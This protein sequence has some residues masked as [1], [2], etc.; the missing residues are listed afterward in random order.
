M[1]AG[2]ASIRVDFFS[3]V[4]PNS[5]LRQSYPFSYLTV[6]ADGSSNAQIL[7][8]IDDSWYG[9]PSGLTP[10]YQ[11]KRATSVISLT[12]SKAVDYTEVNDMA[13]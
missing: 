5:H 8:A 4:S 13:A 2:A 1:D 3:P 12:D 11:T 7:T 9:Q 10:Q 6:A